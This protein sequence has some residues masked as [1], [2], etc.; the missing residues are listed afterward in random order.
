[1]CGA[2]LIWERSRRGLTKGPAARRNTRRSEDP[3]FS[4]QHAPV[5]TRALWTGAGSE[6][7]HTFSA[8]AQV[9]GLR[10]F[11]L[12]NP[13][14]YPIPA[15]TH[16]HLTKIMMVPISSSD[17][18]FLLSGTGARLDSETLRIIGNA[19]FEHNVCLMARG[20]YGMA[21]FG[22]LFYLLEQSD[23]SML[24]RCLDRLDEVRVGHRA[25]LRCSLKLAAFCI[26]FC[27]NRLLWRK[28][29]YQR[30][31]DAMLW[32]FGQ[33]RDFMSEVRDAIAAARPAGSA[34]MPTRARLRRLS[35][36]VFPTE[37]R[38]FRGDFDK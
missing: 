21:E 38:S 36:A 4:K 7:L 33:E 19:R 10:T 22:R 9:R 28:A 23:S 27:G 16:T 6:A 2:I 17:E 31:Y 15:K 20:R 34:R 1:M 24:G 3:R 12:C 32:R 29:A 11:L 25:C 37:I 18:T 5:S 35:L 13:R 26:F 14:G 30:E 8:A